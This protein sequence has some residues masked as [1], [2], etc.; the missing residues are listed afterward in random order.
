MTE[1]IKQTPMQR[2]KAKHKDAKSFKLDNNG[3]TLIQIIA[4][5][6]VIGQATTANKAWEVADNL[7]QVQERVK[8][9]EAAKPVKHRQQP[10]HI[11]PAIGRIPHKVKAKRRAK[12]K[13]A[14]KDR[15][16]N[17]RAA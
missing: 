11:D 14:S 7:M 6:I 5:G 1:V 10:K 8:A 17:R 4:A 3:T 13:Q 9:N 15:A 2:V 12:A 16:R